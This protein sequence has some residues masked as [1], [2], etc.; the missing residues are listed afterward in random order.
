MFLIPEWEKIDSELKE[1]LQY[2]VEYYVK[3]GS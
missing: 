3:K 2:D 1:M